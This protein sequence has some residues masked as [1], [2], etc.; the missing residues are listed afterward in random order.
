MVESHAYNVTVKAASMHDQLLRNAL[1]HSLG[2]C[3]WCT[4][5]ALAH[6]HCSSWGG[7]QR[8][9]LPCDPQQPWCAPMFQKQHLWEP[10][11]PQ[12]ERKPQVNSAWYSTNVPVFADLQ[13]WLQISQYQLKSLPSQFAKSL[14]NYLKIGPVWATQELD[15]SGNDILLDDLF[16][17]RISLCQE[18]LVSDSNELKMIKNVYSRRHFGQ[19]QLTTDD[20]LLLY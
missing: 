13:K 18:R 19:S 9:A 2:R 1:W 6:H 4:I 16:N 10:R 5:P 15:K 14:L 17:R 8:P 20:F 3:S 11:L 7:R 12:T